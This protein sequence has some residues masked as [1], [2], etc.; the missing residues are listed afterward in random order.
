V[1][2]L[3]S[4]T[5]RHGVRWRTWAPPNT[6]CTTGVP[7]SGPGVCQPGPDD[8]LIYLSTVYNDPVQLVLD[9]PV[10]LDSPVA[11]DRTYLYCS[12]YDNGSAP[13]SPSVKRQSTSPDPPI[14]IG[15]LGGPCPDETV[16][17]LD[18]P[19]KGQ[20]CGTQP[21]P[22]GFCGGP[23]LCDACPVKGGV[24]TE[25]EMFILLGNYFV[26]P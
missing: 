3:S 9:P 7:G 2:E 18:G 4:H 17:C 19:Q 5:H 25:D 23:G 11:A 20:L 8:R 10:A 22:D 14:T 21:N 6:P 1:F 12:L 15:F 16:A 26:Q 24:T 13:G